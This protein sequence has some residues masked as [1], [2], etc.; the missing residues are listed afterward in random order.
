MLK[1]DNLNSKFAACDKQKP[2]KKPYDPTKFIRG[3]CIIKKPELNK[4]KG[5]FEYKDW[6]EREKQRTGSVFDNNKGDNAPGN[7]GTQGGFPTGGS[8]GNQTQDIKDNKS[9]I[10][11]DKSI[12]NPYEDINK[13]SMSNDLPYLNNIN[14]TNNVGPYGSG[15]NQ[16]QVGGNIYS[17]NFGNQNPINQSQYGMPNDQFS[18]YNQSQIR[19]NTVIP[20]HTSI[21]NQSNLNYQNNM[22][23]QNIQQQS[24]IRNQSM[25]QQGFQNQNQNINPSNFSQYQN[26]FSTNPNL[27]N[28]NYQSMNNQNQNQNNN[29]S[30]IGNQGVPNQSDLYSFNNYPKPK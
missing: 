12:Y 30:K 8:G 27:Q 5:V 20:G 26:Q 10:E 9:K 15:V 3:E 18:N 22:N 19:S 25:Y 2:P 17:S 14:N 11:I 16:S 1:F 4:E 13:L 29:F 23:P 21:S 7:D 28:P 6:V 24:Q